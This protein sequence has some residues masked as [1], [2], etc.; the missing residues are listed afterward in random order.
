M[1]VFFIQLLAKIEFV[2][3]PRRYGVKSLALERLDKG[4]VFVSL[5]VPNADEVFLVA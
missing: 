5:Q 4:T 1:G 2:D 3:D